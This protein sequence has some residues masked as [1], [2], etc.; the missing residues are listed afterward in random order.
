MAAKRTS[1]EEGYEVN[2][3]AADVRELLLKTL[4]VFA[5]AATQRSSTVSAQLDLGP[6]S[7]ESHIHEFK[8]HLGTAS[9]AFKEYLQPQKLN[10]KDL[11]RFAPQLSQLA[12]FLDNTL[13]ENIVSDLP[14]EVRVSQTPGW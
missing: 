10:D 9:C 8:V 14:A 12:R 4:P 2:P 5:R 3:S 6:D 7:L 11:E 13:D 1:V